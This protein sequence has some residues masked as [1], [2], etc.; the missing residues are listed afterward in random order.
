MAYQYPAAKMKVKK[1]Q[2][3]KNVA[4]RFVNVCNLDLCEFSNDLGNGSSWKQ[5]ETVPYWCC[6]AA[7]TSGCLL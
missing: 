1:I 6:A 3:G 2:P 7:R 5:P 4:V